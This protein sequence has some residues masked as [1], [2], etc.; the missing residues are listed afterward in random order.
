MTKELGLNSQQGQ[1]IF[2]FSTAFRQ[3]LGPI[4]P[5]IQWVLGAVILENTRQGHKTN[6]S[7]PSGAEVNVKNGGAVSPLMQTY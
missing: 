1:E 6:H 5:H 2:L 7:T 3:A 4:K